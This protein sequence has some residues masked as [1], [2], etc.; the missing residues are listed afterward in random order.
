MTTRL[1][2]PAMAIA[3]ALFFLCGL[4]TVLN[5]ILI[6]YLQSI[7]RLSYTQISLIQVSFYLAY[8]L[9]SP[10]ASYIYQQRTYLEGIRTGLLTGSL[11]I[12]MIY[13]A[14][15]N[16]IFPLILS[17]MFLLGAGIAVIQVTANPYTIHLG[18]AHSGSSRLTLA[19]A[20][21]SVGTV[22]APYVGSVCILS[23]T[24]SLSSILYL[25]IAG[26]W[27][28]VC[29]ITYAFHLPTGV[30]STKKQITIQ[31]FPVLDK[32]VIFGIIGIGLATGIEVTYVSGQS[33]R[34]IGD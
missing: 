24:S 31:F 29:L 32:F 30:D 7:L 28:T 22:A 3:M 25:V 10:F 11:G 19:Q 14:A 26:L 13:F 18:P 16:L 4:S 15:A 12:F 21:T 9:F 5:V 20:F 33:P 8:F 2:R 6:P 27:L 23:C 34:K 1:H 17:G